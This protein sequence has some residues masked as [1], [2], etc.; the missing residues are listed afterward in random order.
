M[1]TPYIRRSYRNFYV[2]LI[3]VYRW[4]NN[5]EPRDLTE[6][7]YLF[8]DPR[9]GSSWL[10]QILENVDNRTVIW[11]PFHPTRGLL[12]PSLGLNSKN[13]SRFSIP[14]NVEWPEAREQFESIFKGEKI[15]GYS[16]SATPSKY[17]IDKPYV[18]KFI[19]AN[20]ALPWIT[21]Q[22]DIKAIHLLRHPI[23]TALSQ[24][25]A[26]KSKRTTG[27]LKIP[28]LRYTE[29]Y[30]IHFEFLQTLSSHLENQVALWCIHN[31]EA[32]DH[33]DKKWYTL[34]YEELLIDPVKELTKINSFCD[35]SN[36]EVLKEAMSKKSRT[37]FA[38]DLR[39]STTEQLSKWRNFVSDVELNQVQ[40]VLD[41]F[42]IKIYSTSSDR[43]II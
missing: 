26:F 20:G 21:K 15:N 22:F 14:E 8:S 17:F 34:Y 29:H 5:L 23:S 25:K 28:N 38:G 37:D 27:P 31:K 33:K 32:L 2:L 39:K 30:A 11:E 43:P 12:K 9:G 42:E 7:I 6:N 18:V 16:I 40:R 1:V 13:G 41:Y 35:F 24:I 4:A 36:T 10:S 3:K 19:R